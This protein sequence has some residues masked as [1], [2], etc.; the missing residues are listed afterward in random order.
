MSYPRI[1]L[2]V[3]STQIY[4]DANNLTFYN[5]NTDILSINNNGN[6]GI[7]K[8]NPSSKLDVEGDVVISG[9]LIVNGDTVSVNTSTIN[10]EDSMIKLSNNNSNDIVDSG[11]YTQYIDGGITK[12]SG[13]FRDATNGEYYLYKDSYVEPSSTVDINVTGYSLSNLNI[14]KL[15]T[16]EAIIDSNLGIGNSNPAYELDVNGDINLTGDIYQNGTAFSTSLPGDTRQGFAKIYNLSNGDMFGIEQV[17]SPQSG[18][19]RAEMR[20]FTS[21][22]GAAGIGFGKYTNATNFSH[23]MVIT[24]DGNVGIGET[25]PSYQLELSLNSA[26]KPTSSTWTTTSDRRVKENIV[27][28]DL[29]ICYND[30]KNIPLRRFK[31]NDKFIEKYQIKDKHNLGFIAQ[32]V[33]RINSSCVLTMENKHFK[34][35]DFKTLDKDQLMMSLFGAVKKIQIIQENNEKEIDNF[36]IIN[37]CIYEKTEK[38]TQSLDILDELKVFKF[39]DK[40]LNKKDLSEEDNIFLYSIDNDSLNK[41]FNIYSIGNNKFLP[42]INRNGKIIDNEIE[43]YNHNLKVNDDILIKFDIDNNN[44]EK[45]VKVIEIIDTTHIKIDIQNINN[46]L[47]NINNRKIFIYGK[48]VKNFEYLNLKFL[49]SLIS[50]NISASKEIKHDLNEHKKLVETNMKILNNLINDNKL[51]SQNNKLLVQKIGENFNKLVSNF[52][53]T[54]KKVNQ[55]LLENK[56]IKKQNELFKQQIVLNQKNIN[57]LNQHLN[58]QSIIINQLLQKNK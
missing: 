4:K 46:Y 21:E 12:F 18:I 24:Q 6:V 57:L 33:E 29:D 14:N 31:W 41:Y 3:S 43:I 7:G 34:I 49:Y 17:S 27:N 9:N 45:N 39:I 26:A 20:L 1:I 47:P 44:Y 36:D 11:F 15:N 42:T 53:E 16:T 54:N 28:A 38:V 2:G 52:T 56:E 58:K 35:K 40:N 22:I 50:Y 23:Q 30:I 25:S 8:T 32:E 13:F 5:N 51:T 48:K 10:V 55:L 19:S 37:N